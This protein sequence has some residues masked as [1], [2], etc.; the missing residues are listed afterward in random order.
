M[1]QLTDFQWNVKDIISSSPVSQADKQKLRLEAHIVA[2]P[3]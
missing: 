3:I 2:Q 1:V